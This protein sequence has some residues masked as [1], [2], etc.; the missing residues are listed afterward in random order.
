MKQT[1]MNQLKNKLII[2]FIN[3]Y[4]YDELFQKHSEYKNDGQNETILFLLMTK[5]ILPILKTNKNWS[6]IYHTIL[7]QAENIQI[8]LLTKI[9][10]K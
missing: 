10:Q 6:N 2:K 9:N 4:L 5:W 1:S 3:A 7:N 8:I